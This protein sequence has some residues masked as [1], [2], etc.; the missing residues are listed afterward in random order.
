MTYA[1]RPD[2][3][4]A[5]TH[6]MERPDWI[7][8][9]A[10]PEIRPRLAPFVD[11][12]P[13]SLNV[14][15]DAMTAFHRRRED[16]AAAAQADE[17][18]MSMRH[19]GWHGLGSFDGDERRHVNDLLGFQGGL[20]FPTSA[21]NQ[22][23]AARDPRVFVGGVRALNRGMAA[24]CSADPR[25]IGTAYLP[26]GM[27]PE[28]SLTLLEEATAAGFRVVVVDTIAPEGGLSFTHP[29]YNR[30]WAR[31]QDAGL[32]VALHVGVNGGSYNP[33]PASFYN[34]KRSLPAHI[35]GDAPRDALSYMSI[36]Y[37]AEL[38]LAAMIFDGVLERFPGL[39]LAVVE[40]GASW[41][42]SW[43][44]QL[45]QSFRAFRRLQDLSEV[46]MPPSDYV[47][48]QIKI[49]PFAGEDI[50]WMIG[51]GIEDLLMFASD[52]PHHEGTDDP[53]GRFERTMEGVTETARAKFYNGNFRAL[54]GERLDA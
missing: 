19:K 25:N 16:A 54:M 35:D 37:N 21:F 33:V 32:A 13:E 43:M 39:R 27:G 2:I 42:I 47:R 5:D 9:F 4:D 28:M 31:I 44:K 6:M 52:Y 14:I 8:S 34:N 53:I 26:L 10:D 17:Q 22:V 38:F 51:T 12:R 23:I 40:L 36:Q 7:A 46:K 3:Y 20:V 24:F 48:R 15:A 45:D 18:F 49:T 29:D 50:G 11:G 30:I 41:I 1:H